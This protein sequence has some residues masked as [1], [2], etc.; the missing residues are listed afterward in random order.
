MKRLIYMLLCFSVAV[1]GESLDT[2]NIVGCDVNATN[3]RPFFVT[4]TTNT[5]VAV[6]NCHVQVTDAAT[7]ID[8][9]G[10]YGKSSNVSYTNT[11]KYIAHG[12]FGFSNL[13]VICN[14]TESIGSWFTNSTLL[15][16]YVSCSPE[17]PGNEYTAV[18]ASVYVPMT[19]IV[20]SQRLDDRFWKN[21][22]NSNGFSYAE[23]CCLFCT[24]NVVYTNKTVVVE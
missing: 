23:L 12:V 21:S 24:N 8:V 6:D 9:F 22:I 3:T 1:M 7:G 20:T 14:E 16:T 18:V 2:V 11:P 5:Y 19:V 17:M 13:W 10:V 4:T 15:G